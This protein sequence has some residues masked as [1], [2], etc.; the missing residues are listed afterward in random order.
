MIEKTHNDCIA[1]VLQYG[2][3]K[4]KSEILE[5]HPELEKKLECIIEATIELE[6]LTM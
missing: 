3:N 5:L 4:M 2:M 6:K 1:E